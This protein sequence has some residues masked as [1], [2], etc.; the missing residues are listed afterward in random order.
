MIDVKT[1]PDALRQKQ[2]LQ[3]DKTICMVENAITELSAEGYAVTVSRLM[4]RTGL[5]RSVF[6]KP[7]IKELLPLSGPKVPMPRNMQG[8]HDLTVQLDRAL[9]K[10]EKTQSEFDSKNVMVQKL[11]ADLSAKCDECELLRGKLHVLMQK[12]RIKGINLLE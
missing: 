7:H 9:K 10:L 2:E 1:I 4:E 11:K 12:C 5:S 6:S 8:N 3:R